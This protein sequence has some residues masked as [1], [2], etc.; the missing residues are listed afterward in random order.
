M[1]TQRGSISGADDAPELSSAD[2][3]GGDSATDD[4]VGEAR[5]EASEESGGDDVTPCQDPP[6]WSVK[7]KDVVLE[8][9]SSLQS[10]LDKARSGTQG[11]EGRILLPS[12]RFVG[13]ESGGKRAAEVPPCTHSVLGNGAARTEVRGTLALTTPVASSA[14]ASSL[15]ALTVRL[16]LAAQGQRRGVTGVLGVNVED[17]RRDAYA[18][19]VRGT[20]SCWV[21]GDCVVRATRGSSVLVTR[22]GNCSLAQCIVGG[23]VPSPADPALPQLDRALHDYKRRIARAVNGIEVTCGAS[24]RATN[25]TIEHTGFAASRVYGLELIPC[26]LFQSSTCT[27]CYGML[28]DW[29]AIVGQGMAMHW[30]QA[31]GGWQTSLGAL[32]AGIHWRSC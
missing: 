9:G 25:C 21:L 20:S 13:K 32:C 22:G 23:E 5:L 4:S 1:S 29:R 7:E 12:G 18:V 15:R 28:A 19:Q 17:G 11:I 16:I 24:L 8:A 6:E 30:A 14:L 27:L 26:S 3:I 2:T 10:A 31:R